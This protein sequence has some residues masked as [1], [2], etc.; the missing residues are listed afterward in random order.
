MKLKLT[1]ISL[2]F[3]IV[4]FAQKWQSAGDKIKTSWAEKVTPENVWMEYPRPQME[5]KQWQSLNGLWEY[6]ITSNRAANPEEWKKS[7][8][9]PFAVETP[10]SGVGSRI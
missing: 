5:R 10:L 4:L 8:L 6:A 2:F 9:V 7:I 3:S 1:L